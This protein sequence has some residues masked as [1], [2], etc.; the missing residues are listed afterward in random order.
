MNI[1]HPEKVR[2][3][4]VRVCLSAAVAVVGLAAVCETPSRASTPLGP[5]AAGVVGQAGFGTIKGRLVWGGA[6]APPAKNAV[7][8][9]QASKDPAVC[10]AT[11]AIPDNTLA[12]DPKTK[13]IK[14]AFVYL[15]RPSGENPEAVKTLVAKT[16]SV[17]VDQKN[18]EFIPFATALHQ[19]QKVVF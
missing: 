7:E 19:D 12:V 16:A 14:F 4:C 1:S 8:T 17:V 2:R 11:T 10:A 5:L 9:G 15:V 13:G 3:H 6:E 18:C